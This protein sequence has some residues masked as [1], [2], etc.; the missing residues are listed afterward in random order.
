[1]WKKLKE[2]MGYGRN[3]RNSMESE[4]NWLLTMKAS[5]KVQLEGMKLIFLAYIYWICHSRNDII[6]N[7]K[8]YTVNSLYYC[9]K[10]E[11]RMKMYAQG[12]EMEEGPEKVTMEERWSVIIKTKR[13][14]SEWV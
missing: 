10:E 8:T 2:M 13:R 14:R 1:M 3:I 5:N 7:A 12:Y 6:F 4:I 9:I 11:V